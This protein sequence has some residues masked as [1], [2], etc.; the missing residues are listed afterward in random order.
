[1]TLRYEECRDVLRDAIREE[2]II[3]FHW[4]P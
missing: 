4:T 3:G 2:E 1:L